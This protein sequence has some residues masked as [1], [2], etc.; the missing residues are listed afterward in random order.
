MAEV[1]L[2]ELEKSYLLEL[3]IETLPQLDDTDLIELL[4]E[5]YSFVL[6]TL[7]NIK[8]NIWLI[9]SY[10]SQPS[11]V[12]P[13]IRYPGDVKNIDKLS[14]NAYRAAI[15]V[16]KNQIA[17]DRKKIKRLQ[18]DNNRKRKKIES[19]ESLLN[20]LQKKNLISHDAQNMFS[21]SLKT[22]SSI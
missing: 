17:N 11:A 19:M 8:F 9:S 5:R 1:N 14:P 2:G 4:P 7:F 21:V 6:T 10:Y 22:F 18:S 15:R 13:V 12:E 3:Q 16:L 20:D